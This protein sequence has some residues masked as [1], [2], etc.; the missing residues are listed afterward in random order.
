MNFCPDCENSLNTK[1][2]SDDNSN[3]IMSFVCNNCSYKKVIDI[4]K[5]PEYK[6]VYKQNYNIKKIDISQFNDKYLSKDPTLPHVDIIPCPNP[7]CITNKE[8]PN[9]ELL[10]I[11]EIK[12]NINNV[13]YKKINEGDLTFK[14][15]CCNCKHTWTNK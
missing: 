10:D 14:Y 12:E 8:N 15:Q 7:E 6:C 4:S 1:I 2:S 13:L 3:K 11:G 9:S 5:E